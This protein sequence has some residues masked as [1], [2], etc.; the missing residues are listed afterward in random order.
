MHGEQIVFEVKELAQ[1]GHGQDKPGDAAENGSGHEVG[2]EDRRVPHGDG[3]HGKVP[4]HDGVHGNGDGNNGDCHDVHRRL[5]PVPLP[6]SALPAQGQDSVEF[7]PPAS[8]FVAHQRPIRDDRQQKEGD[9]ARQISADGEEIPHQGRAKLRPDVALAGIGGQPEEEPGPSEVDDGKQAADHQS[10]DG[11]HL[12]TTRH[13]TAPRGVGK[14]QYRRDQRP[15]MADAD[16]EDEVGDVK[17]PEYRAVDSPYADSSPNLVGKG[18]GRGE[19]D[20]AEHGQRE[21]E[22]SRGV[23]QRAQQIVVDLTDGLGRHTATGAVV[24]PEGSNLRGRKGG[25]NLSAS[26][27][28]EACSR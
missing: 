9:A 2:S 1:E 26:S 15:G 7:F 25:Y 12:S 22:P 8:R 5:K 24:L 13:R 4:T 21:P 27:S 20:A 10:K 16:P 6:R 3:S 17:G 11:N 28:Q 18:A 19:H 23:E 14:A